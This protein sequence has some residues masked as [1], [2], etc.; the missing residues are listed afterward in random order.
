MYLGA[1]VCFALVAVLEYL[2]WIWLKIVSRDL[3]V[4]IGVEPLLGR[5]WP[6]IAPTWGVRVLALPFG[7]R[8]AQ[9]C[10]QPCHLLGSAILDHYPV[11]TGN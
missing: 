7:E 6:V 1:E 9:S 8:E 4:A 5:Q 11:G 2:G 10:I 3:L